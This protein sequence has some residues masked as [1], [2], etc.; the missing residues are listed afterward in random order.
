VAETTRELVDS[1]FCYF[2]SVMDD[3]WR[4]QDVVISLVTQGT[5]HWP[6]FSQKNAHA[7]QKKMR[8]V[9]DMCGLKG[10]GIECK[11]SEGDD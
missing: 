9:L 6:I 5:S 3:V 1:L 8:T 2:A 7:Q 10:R 11:E 4:I